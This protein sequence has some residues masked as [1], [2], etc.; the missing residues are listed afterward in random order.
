MSPA[1]NFVT[2]D[3]DREGVGRGIY[4]GDKVLVGTGDLTGL[5]DGMSGDEVRML[6]SSASTGEVGK[7]SEY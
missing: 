3:G 4:G 6:H 1:F 7:C 5:K 2:G